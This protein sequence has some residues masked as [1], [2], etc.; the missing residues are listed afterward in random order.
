MEYRKGTHNVYHHRYHLVWITKYRYRVLTGELQQRV[1][2]LVA[3]AAEDM[4]VNIVNGVVSVDH[5]H[6]FAEIPPHIR[7]SD[8]V[9]R[10]KG[11]S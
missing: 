7:V 8:F 5:I 4:G 6:I 9:Q 2:T 11:R 1:R 3:Q 10:A